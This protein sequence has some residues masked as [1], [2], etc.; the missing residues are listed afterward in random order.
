MER[1][2]GLTNYSDQSTVTCEREVTRHAVR[3]RPSSPLPAA[4]DGA[5]AR[6]PALLRGHGAAISARSVRV[7][8]AQNQL[9]RSADVRPRFVLE[10]AEL[11]L[12]KI[13]IG[14]APSGDNGSN[15]TLVRHRL[16]RRR[17]K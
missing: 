6:V 1:N 4:A 5:S 2:R 17:R 16:D 10:R 14:R 7:Q 11:A 12:E 13:E 15:V 9:Q 8:A 3:V